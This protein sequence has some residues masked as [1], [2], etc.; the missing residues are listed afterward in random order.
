MTLFKVL[1]RSVTF[2]TVIV[3]F[4][5]NVGYVAMVSGVSM[6]PTLNPDQKTDYVFLNKWPVRNF[7]LERGD[8]VSL[9]SPKDQDVKL[10]KRIVGFEGDVI[11]TKN[12]K[13]VEIPRGHCWVEG[14]NLNH[15]YDSNDF[16]TVPVGLIYAKANR[17]IWPPTRWG[18][19]PQKHIHDDRFI[20]KQNPRVTLFPNPYCETKSENDVS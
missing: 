1:I 2:G 13:V 12:K 14:D 4:L 7:E 10:I 8:I 3:T 5:D 17:I 18:Q 6:Q 11:R 16:G 9:L 15:S 19:I 20:D